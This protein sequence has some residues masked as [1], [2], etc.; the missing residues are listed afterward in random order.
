M[1]DKPKKPADPTAE[2]I[3]H[4]RALAAAEQ[5]PVDKAA[6]LKMASGLKAPPKPRTQASFDPLRKY[7]KQ[8]GMLDKQRDRPVAEA[9]QRLILYFIAPK[10]RISFLAFL[11]ARADCGCKYRQTCE[12]SI[13]NRVVFI[14]ARDRAAPRNFSSTL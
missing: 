10:Q 6:F 8:N 12:G 3:A 5:N 13:G 4:Y 9:Q 11:S 7:R 1:T 2:R 14:P